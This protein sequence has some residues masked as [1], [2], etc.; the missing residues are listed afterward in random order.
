MLKSP[1]IMGEARHLTGLYDSYTATEGTRASRDAKSDYREGGCRWGSRDDGF[2]FIMVGDVNRKG[3]ERKIHFGSRSDFLLRLL[4][5]QVFIP[6]YDQG[7]EFRREP[8][9]VVHFV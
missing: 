8:G 1:P 4:Q 6:T 5:K 7:N 2:I 3:E 9:S